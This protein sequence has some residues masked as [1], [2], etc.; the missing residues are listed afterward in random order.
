MLRHPWQG[1][2]ALSGI[3]LGVAAVLAVELANSSARAA[4]LLS[5]QHLQGK[6]THRLSVPG[7]SLPDAIYVEL[8]RQSGAPPMAPVVNGWVQIEGSEGR[9]QLVGFDL[10]AATPFRDRLVNA[11][12]NV[13]F[14]ADWLTQSGAMMLDAATAHTLN[15]VNGDTLNV[16]YRGNTFPLNVLHIEKQHGGAGHDLLLVDIATAKSVLDMANRLSHV[17]LILDAES[18]YWIRQRIPASVKLETIAEQAQGVTRL[19][20]AFELNLTAM[21]L[22]AL[23]VGMFLIFNAVTFSIVQ[24]R[25][26]FGRLRAIGVTPW[27][28]FSL[29]LLINAFQLRQLHTII[30]TRN[31]N[32]RVR[33]D[34]CHRDTVR[35]RHG[36]HVGKIQFT[37]GIIGLQR[38]QPRSQQTGRRGKNAGV[39]FFDLALDFTGVFEFNY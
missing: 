11:P 3:G 15:V 27:E 31:F 28:L 37:L 21:S 24:R 29:I 1:L 35:N 25:T 17:D 22:L 39:N 30:D 33:L 8:Q 38:C 2:L 34:P 32:G 10:F 14:T 6:A 12:V 4:F 26:L 36:N 20:A 23:L 18:E 5:A 9:F 7:A 13:G 16:N 19:S